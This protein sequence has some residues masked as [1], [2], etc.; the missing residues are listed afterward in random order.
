MVVGKMDRMRQTALAVVAVLVLVASCAAQAPDPTPAYVERGHRTEAH[1]KAFRE[2]MERF[3]QALSRALRRNAPDLLREIAP[4]PPGVHGY[5]ILPKITKDGPGASP[6]EQA[7]IVRF[8]WNLT[9]TRI[10]QELDA[11][12]GLETDLLSLGI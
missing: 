6:G 4:P 3:Y 7:H 5:Q 2:R 11:L 12:R 10:E 8:N 1:Q 9:D